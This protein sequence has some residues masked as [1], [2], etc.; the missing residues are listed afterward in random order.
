MT[1]N[2]KVEKAISTKTGT[3][4]E[5]LGLYYGEILVKKIFLTNLEK[6][7]IQALEIIQSNKK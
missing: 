1:Y 5:Y 6:E 4:Y 7:L 3:E 2:V